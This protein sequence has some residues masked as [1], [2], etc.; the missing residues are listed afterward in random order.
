ME[1][2]VPFGIS[3][4]GNYK[5][6]FCHARE[7]WAAAEL[8]IE[9]AKVDHITTENAMVD[10]NGPITISKGPKTMPKRYSIAQ[11]PPRSVT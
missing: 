1:A 3:A 9:N 4:I 8:P 5:V 6:P 7:F 2:E 10:P 11:G